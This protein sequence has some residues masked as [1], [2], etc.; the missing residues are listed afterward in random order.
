MKEMFL[1]EQ[2]KE[3]MSSELRV[4]LAQNVAKKLK[5]ILKMAES[6]HKAETENTFTRSKLLNIPVLSLIHVRLKTPRERMLKNQN[7]NLNIIF[8]AHTCEST[9]STPEKLP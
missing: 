1:V 7:L 6:H 4:L 3:I 8:R 5:D 2:M 9:M